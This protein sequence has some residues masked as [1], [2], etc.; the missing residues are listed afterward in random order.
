M[1]V[2]VPGRGFSAERELAAIQL[3]LRGSS[4]KAVSRELNL[5]VRRLVKWRDQAPI[6]AESALKEQERDAR[7]DEIARL[8]AEVEEIT[9]ANALL[10]AKID[11]LGG[12]CPLARRRLMT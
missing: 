3:L 11:K 7:D 2:A 12:G 4:Q 1:A 8:Q 9:M 6:A 10:C 5:P